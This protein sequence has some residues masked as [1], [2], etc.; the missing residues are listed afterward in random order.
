MSAPITYTSTQITEDYAYTLK[1][2]AI[3]TGRPTTAGYT[4]YRSNPNSKTWYSAYRYSQYHP[5]GT[6]YYVISNNRVQG[7]TATA[8]NEIPTFHVTGS[9]D[10]A[11]LH[12][13]NR[14]P[15]RGSNFYTNVAIAKAAIISDTES[16]HFDAD[17]SKY[18]YYAPQF[19][20]LNFDAGNLNCNYKSGDKDLRNL[21]NIA[22]ATLPEAGVGVLN[23]AN[24]NSSLYLN[25]EASTQSVINVSS[26]SSSL[27]VVGTVDYLVAMRIRIPATPSGTMEILKDTNSNFALS[28]NG[29][30]LILQADNTSVTININISTT[31]FATIIFGRDTT[32]STLFLHITDSTNTQDNTNTYSTPTTVRFSQLQLASSLNIDD[33]YIGA[34]QVWSGTGINYT[35]VMSGVGQS[36]FFNQIHTMYAGR[37]S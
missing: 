11:I 15:N 37:W 22:V 25:A 29:S 18:N 35:G 32:S 7:G 4:N 24:D 21:T 23:M 8:G 19:C 6:G 20:L 10:T 17:L 34:L 36:D 27:D 31:N 5:N 12:L 14:L 2:Y 1:K 28:Y 33:F 16:L 9:T 26:G 13:I 30:N 3:S